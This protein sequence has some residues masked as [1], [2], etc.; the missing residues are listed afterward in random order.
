[1]DWR[2]LANANYISAS[3]GVRSVGE[4]LG[5]FLLWLFNTAGGSWNNVHLVG[6]SLGA[7]VVGNTGRFVGGQPARVTG[8][9]LVLNVINDRRKIVLNL[10]KFY[11][12]LPTFN[13][14]SRRLT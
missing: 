6:F 14:T 1:M 2:V 9:T 5:Q 10:S 8:K 12:Q 3:S 13:G 4:H 7:H 11:K